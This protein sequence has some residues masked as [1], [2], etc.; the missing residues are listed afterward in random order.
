MTIEEKSYNFWI[1]I[2]KY[3]K[4]KFTKLVTVRPYIFPHE[5]LNLSFTIQ[6]KINRLFSPTMNVIRTSVSCVDLIKIPLKFNLNVEPWMSRNS[7]SFTLLLT[8]YR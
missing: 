4:H 8:L 5:L 2:R 7:A 6:E 3:T 1:F